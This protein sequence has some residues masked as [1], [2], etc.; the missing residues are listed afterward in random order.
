MGK[1]TLHYSEVPNCFGMCAATD[2]PLADTCLRRIAFSILPADVIFPS[3]LN[4]KTIEAMAGKCKYYRPNKKVRFAKGFVRT[5]NALTVSAS[6]PFRYGL[7]GKWG[8]RK[9]YQK[10]KG[11]TLLSPDEQQQVIALAK[12]LGLNQEEYFDSYV[13][14]YNW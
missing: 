2:C 10:R 12:K 11:E 14:E 4:P 9:Y 6:G 3:T 1:E 8:I 13:E 5:T 7:I